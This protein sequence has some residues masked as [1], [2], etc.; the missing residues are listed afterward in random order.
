VPLSF[1][2]ACNS[3]AGAWAELS[4]HQHHPAYAWTRAASASR[5]PQTMGEHV[6][7]ANRNRENCCISACRN[8]TLGCHH[9]KKCAPAPTSPAQQG[10]RELLH[11]VTKQRWDLRLHLR[12]RKRLVTI[13]VA[14]EEPT[15]T[16]ISSFRSYHYRCHDRQYRALKTIATNINHIQGEFECRKAPPCKS[17]RTW[18]FRLVA[19]S[20]CGGRSIK[21]SERI[22][23]IISAAYHGHLLG[24]TFFVF[25]TLIHE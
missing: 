18:G 11:V 13:C 3:G 21:S 19:V 6:A 23:R 1:C 12:S 20:D 4:N 15:R 17:A 5:K 14:S 10:E 7:H 8:P 25:P 2:S 16:L 22:I 9:M 24:T